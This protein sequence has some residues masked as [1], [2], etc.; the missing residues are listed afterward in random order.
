M[1]KPFSLYDQDLSSTWNKSK[2]KILNFYITVEFLFF[3]NPFVKTIDIL[4][5]PRMAKLGPFISVYN[6]F[7]QWYISFNCHHNPFL[8]K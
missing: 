6:T 1:I 2:Q 3:L 4:L 8:T 7:V 5:R